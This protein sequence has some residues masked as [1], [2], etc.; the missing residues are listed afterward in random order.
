MLTM[1]RLARFTK[2]LPLRQEGLTLAEVILGL[3]IMIS[4]FVLT[5]PWMAQN[6]R[7]MR[8]KNVAEHAQAFMQAASQYYLA[9]STG[10]LAAM[11]DGTGA[12]SYCQIKADTVLGTGGTTTND[13]TLHTCAV[14]A[15]WLI[16]KSYLPST[17]RATN[18]YGQRLV[19][20]FRRIYDSTNTVASMNADMLMV[21]AQENA[22]TI[23]VPSYDEM[24]TTAEVLGSNGGVTPDKDRTSCKAVRS[25]ATYQ[26]C[27]ANGTWKVDLSQYISAAQLATFAGKLPN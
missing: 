16:Y 24:L 13:A 27:G 18:P 8:A 22:S 14:D 7:D 15:N 3:A 12:A 9:N 26:V 1:A 20:I 6:A 21:G 19:A 25:S 5:I 10:M 4:T 11:A 17:F 2:R 23:S